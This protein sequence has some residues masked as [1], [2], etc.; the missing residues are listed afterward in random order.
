MPASQARVLPLESDRFRLEWDVR[1]D[2]NRTDE[3]LAPRILEC[4]SLR[5]CQ[6]GINPENPNY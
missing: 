6:L 4:G 5:Q 3:T 1:V 2:V